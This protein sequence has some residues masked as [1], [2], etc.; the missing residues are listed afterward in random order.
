MKLKRI[1]FISFIL[2]LTCVILAIALGFRG[3][4]VIKAYEKLKF[5]DVN[6]L[7][8][9]L[10]FNSLEIMESDKEGSELEIEYPVYKNNLQYISLEKEGDLLKIR[11]NTNRI[12]NIGNSFI[13]KK[14][15]IKLIIPK[16]FTF[17]E[18]SIKLDAGSMIVSG[19]KAEST[20]I[21]LNA[22]SLTA[23]KSDFGKLGMELNFGSFKGNMI[24]VKDSSVVLSMG[25]FDGEIRARGS[26]DIN[27]SMGSCKLYT[28]DGYYKYEA[29]ADMG[30][31]SITR[32]NE[33]EADFNKPFDGIFN[34]KVSM[35]SIKIKEN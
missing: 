24:E 35:G 9:D 8:I 7:L 15:S 33:N 16:N 6:K 13:G 25:S 2:G 34:I 20:D 10:D 30:S 14:D 12:F 5:R 11:A 31:K 4:N 1:G 28:Y 18:A 23:K 22:G 17:K 29:D 21:N 26:V 19:F 32:K 27:L 3:F